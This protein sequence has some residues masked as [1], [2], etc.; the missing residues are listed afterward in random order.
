MLVHFYT[1]I[2]YIRKFYFYFYFFFVQGKAGEGRLVNW[3]E[4]AS[5]K[6]IQKLLEIYEL[7]R[8]HEILLT[9]RNFCELSR[10]PSPYI[11]PV[12]PRPFPT[13]IVK[14]EHYVIVDLVSIQD[15]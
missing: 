5:F 15:F 4:K 11:I 8:H 12:I 10:N 1:S 13:E 7:E 2:L 9:T 14:G 6:K 3:V